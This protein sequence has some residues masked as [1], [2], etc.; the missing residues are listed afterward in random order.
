[1][2]LRFGHELSRGG[3]LTVEA[4]PSSHGWHASGALPWEGLWEASVAV[5]VDTFTEEQGSCR[6][7]IAP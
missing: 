7:A 4:A 3:P 1:V 2:T 5:R 6:I